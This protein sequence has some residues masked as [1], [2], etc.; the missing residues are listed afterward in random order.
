[1]DG[2]NLTIRRRVFP[3]LCLASLVAATATNAQTE[4][5]GP[6]ELEIDRLVV[7]TRE[8]PP[9][10]IHGKD[11]DW[12]GISIE[13]LREVKADLEK[14]LQHEIDLEFRDL[15]LVDMLDAVEQGEVDLAAGAITVNYERE[16]R[17]DF[18]H[19]FYHSGL[20]I[21]V[22]AANRGG[23]WWGT[24]RAILSPT[25]LG[26]VAALLAA[27][28][29]SAVAVY[30]FE[31]RANREQ[32]GGG[33][34]RGIGSGLWWA[35]VTL[36]TVGYGDKAPVTLPGRLIGLVWMF[37]GLFIIA[38][39]TAAVTSALTLTQL[40]ADI[41]GP[42]DLSRV[43]VATVDGSTAAAYLRA[44]HIN[45]QQYA[46]A[47]E[48]LAELASDSADAVVYDAPILRYQVL[49]D[50]PG[51]ATVLPVSFAEQSYAFP[52]PPGSPLRE[53]INQVLLRQVDSPDW[54]ELLA[55]YLGEEEGE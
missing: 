28:G 29:L 50:Y 16:K 24:A 48:A 12:S 15:S 54:K 43:R 14:E 22:A 11:G 31:R 44:R 33:A 23:G 39:F 47:G 55:G 25:F 2:A 53:R 18:S 1:M 36:T 32:F 17:M 49:N 37:A 9:F 51:E 3:F 19:P 45:A 52:L 21:A 46:T 42:A 26:I 38:S 41:S 6:G 13:L 40:K 27:L 7:A 34:M 5:G 4:G 20:G 10:A 35:A 30:F 8:V